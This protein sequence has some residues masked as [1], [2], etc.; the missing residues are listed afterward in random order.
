[1]PPPMHSV[2]RPVGLVAALELVED[3]AEQHAAGGAERVAEGDRAAVDI[4]LV[5]RGCRGRA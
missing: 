4:D 1:M 5:A 3:G 2:T